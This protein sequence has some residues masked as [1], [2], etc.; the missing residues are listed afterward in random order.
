MAARLEFDRRPTLELGDLL[1]GVE[2]ADFPDSARALPVAGITADSRQV[3]RGSLFVAIPGTRTDGHARIPE[4]ISR[5]AAAVLVEHEIDVE[6]TVP[7]VRV[8]NARQALAELAAAWHGHPAD[9][10][11]LVGITGTIGKTSV[12]KML[13]VALRAGGLRIGTIG[14]L[15]ISFADQEEPTGY[16]APDPLLLQGALK[17]IADSGCDLA[18][19]EVT[20]HALDQKRVHGLECG[21]GI[22]TNLVPL[23]HMDYHR[24]FRAYVDVKRRF[25]DHLSPGAPLVHSADD[26]A[27]R[28]MVREHDVTPIGCGTSRGAIVRIESLEMDKDGTAL[29][30]NIREPLRKPGGGEVPAG[31]LPLR[32]R[33]LGRSNATNAA[34]AATAALCLGSEAGTVESALRG[35]PPPRRRMEVL[36][37]GR[38]TVLDDTV[39]HPDSV[40]ALFE[41]V[42]RLSPPRVH[43]VFSI[44]GQRGA[45]INRR[46]AESLAIWMEKQ[47]VHTLVVT[48]SVDAADERNRVEGT[49]REAFL[50]PLRRAGVR[51]EEH[52]A[53]SDA[54]PVALDRAG[55]G[56]L[57]LLLGAQGMDDGAERVRHWLAA[58][59]AG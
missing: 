29:V 46:I 23:E 50:E 37:C 43:A 31:I 38:F 41:V 1:V 2:G 3:Q 12:L 55:E 18:A 11:R 48:R 19:M 59:G 34:L 15:G 10:L 22:F 14:S 13:E 24:S 16:T 30:L 54:I 56:D 58:G 42:E 57:V 40:S 20:S 32:T 47:P 28:R 33:L 53:L 7:R 5:G 17:R 26:H 36:P 52:D 25:F 51:F 9:R 44:R 21:L 27:V 4:A 49:E 39:G 35:F 6:P 8:A 45:R